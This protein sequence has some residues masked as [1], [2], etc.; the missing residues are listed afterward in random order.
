M[1]L[2]TKALNLGLANVIDEEQSG[3]MPGSN[4]IE[5]QDLYK[6]TMNTYYTIA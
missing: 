4:T 6:S 2:F 1:L 5:A 3:I